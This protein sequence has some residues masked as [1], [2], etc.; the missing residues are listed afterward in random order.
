FF[1]DD[2]IFDGL[3]LRP[4]IPM[5]PYS[6]LYT[7]MLLPTFTETSVVNLALASGLLAYALGIDPQ[8][9]P[10]A[11]ATGQGVFSFFVK[12]HSQLDATWNHQ[13]GQVEIDALFVGRR[14]SKDT[15]FVIEAKCSDKFGSF[16]KHK[17]Y[18]ALAALRERLP[19]NV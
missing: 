16:A 19:E 2:K 4:F 12:P 10:S 11:P 8:F 13:R 18:Y 6:T 7:F 3:E 14:L 15:L 5:V 1:I 9:V 17:L